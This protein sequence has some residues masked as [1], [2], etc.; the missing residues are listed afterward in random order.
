MSSFFVVESVEDRSN[1]ALMDGRWVAPEMVDYCDEQ[2]YDWIGLLQ[3]DRKIELDR[4]GLPPT[5]SHL[6]SQKPHNIAV[7]ALV[8]STLELSYQRISLCQQAYWSYTHSLQIVGLGKVRFAIYFGNPKKLGISIVLVTNRLDW[9][10]SKILTN[11]TRNHSVSALKFKERVLE[12]P[13]YR[14][15][16]AV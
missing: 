12:M 11:W 2:S 3:A 10:T 9:S 6:L 4:L 16:Q 14:L 5:V 1:V 13:H 8:K 15:I 7:S